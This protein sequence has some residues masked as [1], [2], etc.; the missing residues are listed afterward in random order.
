M[1]LNNFHELKTEIRL[2][3]VEKRKGLEENLNVKFHSV[4]LLFSNDFF[5]ILYR[6]SLGRIVKLLLLMQKMKFQK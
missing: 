1:I 2:I 3:S 6:N 4:W 5:G